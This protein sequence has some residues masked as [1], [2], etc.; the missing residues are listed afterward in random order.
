MY[1]NPETTPGGRALKFYSSVRIDIRKADTIKN[2]S[3]IIGNKVKVKVVKNKVAAPFKTVVLE[4]MYGEGVSAISNLSI[5]CRG[6][7]LEKRVPGIRTKE[8]RSVKEK[9]RPKSLSRAIQ[10]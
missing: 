8:R 9:K 2:G 1:G 6:G 4:I 3:D 5:L 7:H 10:T